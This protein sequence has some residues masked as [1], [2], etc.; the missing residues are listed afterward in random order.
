MSEKKITSMTTESENSTLLY[1]TNPP[2]HILAFSILILTM[3][4]PTKEQA[5]VEQVAAAM[6]RPNMGSRDH[7]ASSQ[8]VHTSE[9]FSSRQVA[10]EEQKGAREFNAFKRD[11]RAKQETNDRSETLCE[12]A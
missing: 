5:A 7:T 12:Q 4:Q 1:D 10:P 11:Y 2:E 8:D 9:A 6:P 3:Y